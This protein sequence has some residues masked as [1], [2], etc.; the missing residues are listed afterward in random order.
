MTSTPIKRY[1]PDYY[2]NIQEF[3]YGEFV[4]Y[5]DY[6][7]A[8]EDATRH[9]NDVVTHEVNSVVWFREDGMYKLSDN[10]WECIK[11]Y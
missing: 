9:M 5:D 11:K 10:G 2:G 4:K 8:L 7:R 3:E 6:R 1:E